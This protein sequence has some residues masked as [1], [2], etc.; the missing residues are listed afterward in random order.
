MDFEPYVENIIDK[1]KDSGCYFETSE[2]EAKMSIHK[3]LKKEYQHKIDMAAFDYEILESKGKSQN[4][5]ELEEV[6]LDIKNE[7]ISIIRNLAKTKL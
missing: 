4:S 5:E 1:L 6:F 7:M 2:E 3:Y